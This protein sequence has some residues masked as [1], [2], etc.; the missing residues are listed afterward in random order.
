MS[1]TVRYGELLLGIE[2]AAL[3]RHLLA[4]DEEFIQQRV[5]AIRSLAADFDGKR[6]SYGIEAPELD[7]AE[8]YT[9]WAPVYDEMENA[10]IRAEEPLVASVTRDLPT[11]KALDVACGTGR[12][13]AWL[14]A[15]GH[16]TT[17]IDATPAMLEIARR[18]A[19][20]VDFELGNLMQLPGEDGA[21]D[22][23]ICALALATLAQPGA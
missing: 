19:P 22:F 15:A 21:F 3:F 16:A 11:G 18:R 20:T 8:G 4:D 23:A 1:R 2:G 7:I 10:L 14:A 17:G 13:A 12:H 6:L 5:D 9:A